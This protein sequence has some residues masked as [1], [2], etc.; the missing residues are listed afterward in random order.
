MN[1]LGGDGS[2]LTGFTFTAGTNQYLVN[3][4]YTNTLTTRALLI[5]LYSIAAASAGTCRIFFTNSGVGSVY[6]LSAA[7]GPGSATT[8]QFTIPLNPSATFIVTN[9]SG[10][11]YITNTIL[12]SL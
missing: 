10:S 11:G 7:G 2:R 4:L 9:L 3:K 12:W 6:P 5:G 8:F 1:N